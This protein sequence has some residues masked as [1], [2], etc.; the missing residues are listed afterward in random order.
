MTDPE[1]TVVA[2]VRQADGGRRTIPQP[3]PVASARDGVAIR[4]RLACDCVGGKSESLI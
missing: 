4:R 1:S 2:V 3:M